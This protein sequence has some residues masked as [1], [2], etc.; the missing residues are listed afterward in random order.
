MSGSSIF[1][2]L[3]AEHLAL[4]EV[5]GGE[6]PHPERT[7][8]IAVANQKG[9]VGKT[10]TAVNLAAALAEG[11]LHVLLIDADSQGNASTALG[12]EHDEDSASIYDVLVDAMPIKDVVAKT[13][14][15]ESL[16]CV[17]A[18]IDVAA[19]EIELISTAERESRLR[20]ALV[21]Y[22]VSRETE[23]VFQRRSLLTMT[24]GPLWSAL[25]TP[26]R[27]L[28]RRCRFMEARPSILSPSR[29]RSST[30]PLRHLRSGPRR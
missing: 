13:R 10:S 20:R 12:V 23:V 18:T 15:C 3:Q 9:G 17:P 8:V 27:V 6:F 14:F 1:D 7:R 19:V 26:S 28:D 4:D 2:Q 29:R 22:L 21:D 11:G 24:A 5:A 25:Q 16:W 30:W